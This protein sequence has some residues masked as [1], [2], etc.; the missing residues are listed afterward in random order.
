MHLTTTLE[1][2]RLYTVED[3]YTIRYVSTRSPPSK[4]KLAK[5]GKNELKIDEIF[6][7]VSSRSTKSM[8]S[9]N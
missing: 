7:K 6:A 5:N 9:M 1:C 2:V 3:N 8:T 4:E